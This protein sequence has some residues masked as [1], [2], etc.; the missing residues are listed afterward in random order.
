MSAKP[1]PVPPPP[2]SAM[3]E[4]AMCDLFCRVLGEGD[5]LAVLKILLQKFP[6]A[7][8]RFANARLEFTPGG[9]RAAFID[10]QCTVTTWIMG[11]LEKS[12]YMKDKISLTQ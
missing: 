4:A 3:D 11:K 1:R 8:T 7:R 6:P 12:P 2:S 5:G 9:E 10:G